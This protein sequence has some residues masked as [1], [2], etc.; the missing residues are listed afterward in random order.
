[1][2]SGMLAAETVYEA[3]AAGDEGH[4]DLSGYADRF[5]SSWLRDELHRT[6]N[7]GP[8]MHKF[9]TWLG[10]AFNFLDQNI[11]RGKLPF[12]LKDMSRD[13]ESLAPAAQSAEINYPKP[14]NQL[15]FDKPSSVFLS[16]TNHE[17]DQPV[18]LQ[19]G[20]P[21]IPVGTNLPKWAE[22]AQRYCPAGV[23]EVIEE[24]AG[25]PRFQIKFLVFSLR[26]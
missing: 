20:D 12:T 13:H 22:P 23:Y 18:H 15:S 4:R 10:G 7:F 16:S 1:M 26:S 9:G 2:K 3:L 11:F 5:N 8:A 25:N 17:E 14:D 24:E 21:A 19:L 6:R